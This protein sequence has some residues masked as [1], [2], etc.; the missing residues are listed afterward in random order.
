MT[1][2]ASETLGRAKAVATFW[3]NPV[4]VRD[5]RVRM[6]GARSYWHLAIY[7][8]LLSLLAMA[9][10]ATATQFASNPGGMNPVEMQQRLQIFYYFIFFTLAGLVCLIA[11]ALTATS[12]TTEKQRLTL[13]LLVTTP[14]S[15]A[16]MLT[17]K[18]VSSIAFLILLLAMSLPASALCVILGGATLGDVFRTYLLLAMD[19]LVLSAVGLY[20]SCTQKNSMQALVSTYS[21]IIGG[22][23]LSSILVPGLIVTAITGGAPSSNPLL[24]IG[25]LH[26]VVAVLAPSA[27][28]KLAG[29]SVPMWVMT[30]IAAF[31]AIRLLLTGATYRMGSYGTDALGSLRR[32]VLFITGAAA[33][34]G[35]LSLS[36]GGA[37]A[38]LGP[39]ARG[40][41]PTPA[42]SV[43]YLMAG[44]FVF[45]ALFLPS[46]FTPTVPEGSPDGQPVDGTYDMRRAFRA[47]HA[48]ALPFFH[49]WLAILVAGCVLGAL[50]AGA[51]DAEIVKRMALATLYVA[52]MGFATWSLCRRIAALV[53]GMAPARYVSFA[54][55]VGIAVL[56]L[57]VFTYATGF[58]KSPIDHPLAPLWVLYPLFKA[59][60]A[61]AV[62]SLWISIML[63]AAAGIVL[64]PCFKRAVPAAPRR[65]K[66]LPVFGAPAE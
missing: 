41:G 24:A 12:I 60:S 25:A 28:I 56:P 39:F 50:A 30:M 16:E 21:A 10:Y 51:L 9:G 62:S 3:R 42:A 4:V 37:S 40:G 7:L 14:M 44:A 22:L 31:I 64:Y 13:D 35:A 65:P 15:S 49:I 47:V 38:A 32:Q 53:P 8:G 11:P 29:V 43:E 55:L 34:L 33:F 18:L 1:R 23:W 20:M 63:A 6:R 58:E 59:G 66:P 5:L 36:A 54:A 46:L 57:F 61:E 45:C 17:G 52:A 27:V 2:W 19:G 26:P 48:G